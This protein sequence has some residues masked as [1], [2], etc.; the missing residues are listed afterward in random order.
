VSEI[1]KMIYDIQNN[2]DNIVNE[3]DEDS[4][5][6]CFAFYRQKEGIFSHRL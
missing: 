1:D 4:Y 6:E 2:I 3:I 5:V